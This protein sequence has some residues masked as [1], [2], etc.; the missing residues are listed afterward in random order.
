[1]QRLF[2]WALGELPQ[3]ERERNSGQLLFFVGLVASLAML[4]GRFH[5]LRSAEVLLNDLWRATVHGALPFAAA[6]LWSLR[7]T[8]R[9]F[10]LACLGA[11]A[12]LA[13]IA[14]RVFS[15]PA[16]VALRSSSSLLAGPVLLGVLVLALASW[17]SGLSLAGWGISFGDL[18]WWLPRAA[19]CVAILLPG[20]Y[21]AMSLNP[22]LVEYYPTLKAARSDAGA[23]ALH[24]TGV[25][26]DFF[27]WEFLFRGF[28]LFG[29]ARRGDSATAIWL[30]AIP[31]FLLHSRKPY[32][33]LLS[34][35][36][37]GLAAGWFCLRARTFL[38]LFILHW[39]QMTGVGLIANFLRK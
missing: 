27:G 25:G 6:V 4:L 32:L 17:R 12:V 14:L 22:P 16:A 11:A 39:I 9:P 33:E 38:P 1:M 10:W 28:L 37:G 31:F 18:R 8:K 34:S 21:L 35:L 26:I 15:E 23:F 7:S 30:Q 5:G 2:F 29:I 24:H 36:V 20:I 19:L 13:P 3:L